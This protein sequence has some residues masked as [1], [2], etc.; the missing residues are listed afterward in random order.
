MDGTDYSP[1]NRRVAMRPRK[2]SEISQ[3]TA[4]SGAASFTAL[5][6]LGPAPAA[7]AET[8]TGA[9]STWVTTASAA[10]LGTSN[11]SVATMTAVERRFLMSCT[12]G[13][14]R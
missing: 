10:L 1:R 3:A 5:M 7:K 6:T 12:L 11:A 2:P 9:A 4:G 8:L 13:V 14:G